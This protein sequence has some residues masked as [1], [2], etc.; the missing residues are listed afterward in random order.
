ML[1][2]K[3]TYITGIVAIVT[4]VGAYLAGELALEPAA[5]AVLT[6]LLGMFIRQG[7]TTEAS[8]KAPIILLGVLLFL[9]GCTATG[10]LNKQTAEDVWY[11]ARADLTAANRT[12][13]AWARTADLNDRDTALRVVEIGRKLQ[14]ARALLA[15]AKLVI[16]QPDSFDA[17]ID[18]IEALLTELAV[19]EPISHDGAT[20]PDPRPAWSLRSGEGDQPPTRSNAERRPAHRRAA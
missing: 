16:D 7:V 8:K 5:Q 18:R 10:S 1:K 14:A 15:E 19:P 2:G 6:A 12:Y 20:S 11:N 17:L 3:K 4:V 9:G 13:L